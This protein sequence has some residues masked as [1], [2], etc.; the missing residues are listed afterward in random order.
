M[1]SLVCCLQDLFSFCAFAL[2]LQ[3]CLFLAGGIPYFLTH[4]A[5]TKDVILKVIGT[6]VAAVPIAIPTVMVFSN[7]ACAGKLRA[8][9]IHVLDLGKLRSAAD[10]SIACFDKTGTLTSS[11]VSLSLLSSAY[12]QIVTTSTAKLQLVVGM[13]GPH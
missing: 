9:G 13:L 12:L 5:Y 4:E 2:C 8:K 3:S 7:G 10:V 1:T 6:I 11:V